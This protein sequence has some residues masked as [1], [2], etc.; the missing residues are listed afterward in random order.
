MSILHAF[1]ETYSCL[2][3]LRACGAHAQCCCRSP[4]TQ[5]N[6]DFHAS[7]I[8]QCLLFSLLAISRGIAQVPLAELVASGTAGPGNGP[9][10]YQPTVNLY[11]GTF[12]FQAYPGGSQQVQLDPDSQLHVLC[13]NR[14]HASIYI[15]IASTLAE[16][17]EVVTV[18]LNYQPGLTLLLLLSCR[19]FTMTRRS[20]NLSMRPQVRLSN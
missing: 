8:L 7:S 13:R 1:A 3:E 12:D 2:S 18:A 17:A 20:P 11:N 4:D 5:T 16:H 15:Y 19:P 9:Q 14:Q 10:P 6:M